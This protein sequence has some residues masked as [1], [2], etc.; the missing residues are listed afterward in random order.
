MVSVEAAVRMTRDGRDFSDQVVRAD[1]QSLC[2]VRA[3]VEKAAVAIVAA[4]VQRSVLGK[5]GETQLGGL[6]IAADF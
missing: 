2:H 4:D 6:A 5:V 1:V 3:Y